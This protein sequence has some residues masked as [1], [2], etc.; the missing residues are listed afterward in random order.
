VYAK[1][2]VSLSPFCARFLLLAAFG[3][4]FVCFPARASSDSLEDAAR[5]LAVKICAPP[6][7]HSVRINWEASPEWPG[8]LSDSVRRAF[9]A[10]LSACGIE[11]TEKL[12]DPLLTITVRMSASKLF[13][14]AEFVNASESRRIRIV[15]FPSAGLASSGE[16][17]PLIHLRKE[18]L[19]RQER[20]IDSALEWSDQ[21][22]Q[23]RFLFLLS[24]GSLV[25]LRLDGNAW[26]KVDATQ[27]PV[28]SQRSRGGLGVFT[29]D[30]QAMK[31]ELLFLGELC[32]VDAAE[33]VSFA[34]KA[35]HPGGKITRLSPSC[36]ETP[37]YLWSRGV[38]NTQ[39]DRVVMSSP[40][41]PTNPYSQEEL[42]LRSLEMPGPVL[43]ITVGE[44][45]KAAAA[46][47]KNLATGDYEV[48]RLTIVC[49]D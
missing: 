31:P 26:S 49:G 17:T 33:H 25:R 30:P 47:V 11:N 9:L 20:P 5:G 39:R 23:G 46:A 45:G 37:Q 42:Y 7:E 18:L 4:L 3:V 10:Q 27:L 21:S 48:Y 6:R 16:L 15:E 24:E 32:Q 28:S 12:A 35:S 41:T 38:D 2:K 8:L 29:Y 19:W 13:L 14:I 36:G 43:D 34:C 22:V 1:Q 40:Q 44:G